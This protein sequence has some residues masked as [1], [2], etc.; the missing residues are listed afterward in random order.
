V[1]KKSGLIHKIPVALGIGLILLGASALRSQQARPGGRATNYNPNCETADQPCQ[2]WAQFRL[3]HPYPYQSIQWS[4]LPDGRIA[5]M[6]LEPP[7]VMSKGELES[8]IRAA[9]KGELQ[10]FDRFRWKMGLDGWLEDTVLTIAPPREVKNSDPLRDG[11]FRDRIAFLHLAL[12][13]TVFGATFDEQKGG[14]VAPP[15]SAAPNL[16]INPGEVRQ[17]MTDTTTKWQEVTDPYGPDLTWL[18]IST[19]HRAGSYISADRRLVILTFPVETLKRGLKDSSELD[20]LRVPFRCFALAADSIAGA[21][22]AQNGQIAI[23]G[24]PRTQP[25][26]TV[27]PLRFETF[28]LLATQT[29]RELSQSY[30]RG[31]LFAGK[32]RSGDFVY[33]DWAPIYLSDALID[34]EFGALLNTTDQLLK[35]WS[36]AGHIEYLYFNYAKP[37]GNAYPFQTALSDRVAAETGAASVLYNWNTSGST[38]LVDTLAGKAMA[39][40]QTGALPV[41]YGAGPHNARSAKLLEDEETAYGYFAERKDPNLSRVVQYATLYQLFRAVNGAENADSP[42]MP[43]SPAQ[44]RVIRARH[45]AAAARMSATVKLLADIHAGLVQMNARDREMLNAKLARFRLQSPTLASDE[46]T[47]SVLADRF[48][49]ESKVY[50]STRTSQLRARD[51]EIDDLIQQY[52]MDLRLTALVSPEVR[53]G[54]PARK[55]EIEQKEQALNEWMRDS[56]IDD[57]RLLLARVAAQRGD[58]DQVRQ[59]FVEAFRYEPSGNIKTPSIVISWDS[60]DVVAVG[61]HNVNSRV[62]KFEPTTSV[63]G[64]SIL[65]TSDGV[66]VRYNPSKA[67]LVEGHATELARAVEHR[68]VNGVADL[69]KIASAPITPRTRTVALQLPRTIV[70]GSPSDA[71]SAKLGS[72]VYTQKTEFTGHLSVMAE[73]SSCCEFIG[74]DDKGVAFA[75][76]RSLKPPPASVIYELRDTPSLSSYVDT[77]AKKGRALIFLDTP[78]GHVEALRLQTASGKNGQNLREMAEW[79]GKQRPSADQPRFDGI[80][81]TDLNGEVGVLKTLANKAEAGARALLDRLTFREPATTWTEAQV[82]HLDA[83][84]AESV[85]NSIGW[86]LDKDGS[87]TGVM[88]SFNKANVNGPPIDISVIAGFQESQLTAGSAEL[89]VIQQKAFQV[90]Q[91]KRDSLARYALT[92]K[93]Q[94]EQ[95]SGV[96]AKR[97]A[98]VVREGKTKRLLT[99]LDWDDNFSHASKHA[100]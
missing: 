69:E 53:A 60:T 11:V 65:E 41:T 83:S 62:L 98:I 56:P 12:F 28:K 20:V 72:H 43:A 27:P 33:R 88:L 47:A 50:N 87:P 70:P 96:R 45:E 94:M 79:L 92:V 13:G 82:R 71:W 40:R 74:Y 81:A 63:T 26:F 73:R 99:W 2:A 10:S 66:K 8:L 58:L 76:E 64:I 25:V 48:S 90:A 4:E 95:V 31:S 19:K 18:S 61:G 36:E 59:K 85:V 7:P 44:A 34:T 77:A 75:T 91:A 22:Q 86:D 29:Q 21:F 6:L 55:K 9:F 23:L 68:H 24:R 67:S 39:T 3:Q 51:Q 30:E 37:E 1:S 42:N 100:G 35:S 93:R 57:A 16:K 32:M 46:K 80:A 78:E 97:L 54:L 84:E 5:V 38:V 14:V 15:S 52:N 49:D 17:W 89:N